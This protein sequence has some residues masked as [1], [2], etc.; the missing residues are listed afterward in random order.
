M[1]LAT[2]KSKDRVTRKERFFYALGGAGS[3]GILN[4]VVGT[5]IMSYYT[6]TALI[7]AAA[8]ASMFIIARLF[9]GVTDIVMG[10]LIDKTNTKIGKAR[11]WVL[12]SAPLAMISFI[13]LF[14][15]PSGMAESSKVVYA[16]FTYIFL[17]CIVYTINNMANNTLGFRM[18]TNQEDRVANGAF[19]FMFSSLAAVVV[20]I[21]VP[22]MLQN[23]TWKEISIILGIFAFVT[24]GL[25]GLIV[26][27]RDVELVDQDTITEKPDNKA[28]LKTLLR[29]KYFYLACAVSL[30]I[31]AASTVNMSAMVY[32][33][34]VVLQKPEMVAMMIPITGLPSFLLN[35][36]I[37]IL[38][39]KLKKRQMMMCGAGLMILGSLIIQMGGSNLA[40]ALIGGMIRQFGQ[41]PIFATLAAITG[42]VADYIQYQNGIRS[43]GL[44]AV[45]GSLGSKLGMGVGNAAIAV[46]LAIVGYEAATAASIPSVVAGVNFTFG[47]L[48]AV[49]AVIMF[50]VIYFM[51]VEDDVEKLR[52]Q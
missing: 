24:I 7:G 36:I 3:V 32:Y 4:N 48:V 50:I 31:G 19:S 21:I 37:P 10:F 1:S 2:E 26:K 33:C 28:T 45:A 29:C 11:P 51:K 22:I 35:L 14:N 52:N 46:V 9:D 13:L 15:V 40:I 5:F 20:S 6:D 27:E 16:Y 30:L 38:Y 44:V 43:D 8:L 12:A 18:T 17:N 49:I 39:K 42:D 23:Q 25:E 47:G 34:N 41:V